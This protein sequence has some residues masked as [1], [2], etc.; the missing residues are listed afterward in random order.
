MAH[1]YS[2]TFK[3]PKGYVVVPSIIKGKATPAGKV[4]QL[5]NSGKLKPLGG[6]TFKTLK[7][8]NDWAKKRS[9]GF[10]K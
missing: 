5:L 4:E 7:E 10:G 3:T 2:M 8:A 9:Q 6:K 1:E